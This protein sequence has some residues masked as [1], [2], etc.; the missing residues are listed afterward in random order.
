MQ[1]T[2][3]NLENAAVCWSVSVTGQKMYSQD[4]NLQCRGTGIRGPRKN[5]SVLHAGQQDHK[6]EVF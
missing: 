5:F 2:W 4:V 6:P 1:N 3:E